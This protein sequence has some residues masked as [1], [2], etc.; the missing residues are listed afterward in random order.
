M[1]INRNI[2]SSI[3]IVMLAASVLSNYV[4]LTIPEYFFIGDL[5][6]YSLLTDLFMLYMVFNLRFC[7]P[8]KIAVIGLC[9][10]TMFSLLNPILNY[11][12]YAKIYDTIIVSL[13]ILFSVIAYLKKK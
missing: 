11:E 5:L 1:R 9:A 12:T 3:P 4:S 7:I 2:V 10:L 8:T 6:G 13:C